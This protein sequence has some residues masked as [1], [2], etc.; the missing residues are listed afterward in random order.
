MQTHQYR[1][2][3][4]A[5]TQDLMKKG[6]DTPTWPALL[7]EPPL[8]TVGEPGIPPIKQVVLFTKYR[9]LIPEVFC[10]ITCPDPGDDIKMKIKSERNTKQ[11]E[12]SKKARTMKKEEQEEQDEHDNSK[13]SEEPSNDG[14]EN[15]TEGII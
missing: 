3:T 9:A 5:T 8:Q 6:T 10:D 12:K 7:Q 1:P 4:V 14:F 2:E 15:M 11:Q 13:K